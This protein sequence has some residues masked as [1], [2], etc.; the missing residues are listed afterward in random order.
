MIDQER[1][2]WSNL[3]AENAVKTQIWI[4]IAVY[5]PDRHPQEEVGPGC[6]TLPNSTGS[7]P[8]PFRENAHFTSL[9][10]GKF[11][12]KSP[13]FSNQLNLLDF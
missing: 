1:E 9:R 5:A 2:Y 7:Q 4:A 12:E 11:Q 3:I 10:R 13:L 6:D 8:H